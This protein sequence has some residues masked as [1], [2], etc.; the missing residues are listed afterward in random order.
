MVG[1]NNVSF[2]SSFEAVSSQVAQLSGQLEIQI[3]SISAS[4]DDLID[5][6]FTSLSS[7]IE[8]T[9]SKIFYQAGQLFFN[10]GDTIST[11]VA[12]I[13]PA[14]I[15]LNPSHISLTFNTTVTPP[16]TGAFLS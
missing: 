6:K 9:Y 5:Q 13:V 16:N 3:S 14:G 11:S 2:Y 12:V 1:P 8:Q 7:T 4:T 15:E 10:P